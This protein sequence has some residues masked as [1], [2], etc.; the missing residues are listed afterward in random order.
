MRSSDPSTEC[1][2]MTNQEPT[3]TKGR[4]PSGALTV[5][6]YVQS[7]QIA[8]FECQKDRFSR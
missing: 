2:D 4:P 7:G 1:V 3:A 8:P 6:V 5:E